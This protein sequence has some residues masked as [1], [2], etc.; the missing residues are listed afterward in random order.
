MANRLVIF[1]AGLK[2][3]SLEYQRASEKQMN[4]FFQFLLFEFGSYI[5]TAKEIILA[6]MECLAR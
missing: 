1:L 5:M 2:S 4:M 3:L 6:N